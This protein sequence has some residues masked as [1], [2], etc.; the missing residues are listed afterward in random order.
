MNG[1][2]VYG[3]GKIYHSYRQKDED[4]TEYYSETSQGPFAFGNQI[5]SD[6]P[7]SF[8]Q[9]GLSFSKL[10]NVPSYPNYTGWQNKNGTPFHFVS[11]ED[12]DKLGDESTVEYCRGIIE[13]AASD[14][15]N[16]PFFLTAGF[17]KPHRPFHIPEKYWDLYDADNFNMMFYQ[18]DSMIP[19]N[20]AIVNRFGSHSNKAFDIMRAESPADDPDFY[21]RQYIHGYYA[22]ISFIDDQVGGILMA[23]EEWGLS[24][25]T[26]V[27]FTSDHG[28]HLGSKG[29]VEK[30][31][32]W[33]DA[34]SV[35]FTIKIPGES[36][37][38][39][40]E[41]ISLIDLYP[42]LLTYGN[43]PNPDSHV[44][45]GQPIQNIIN[46]GAE[47]SAILAGAALEYLAVGEV[48]NVEHNHHGFVKNGYK[49]ICYSSGEDE[50]YDIYAD[51]RET[52][53]LSKKLDFQ[54]IRNSMHQQLRQHIGFSF[55]PLAGYHCLYYGD[56]EQDL[57]GWS[58]S[59]PDQNFNI[60]KND[61]ILQ[62]SHL[63]F[64][65]STTASIGNNNI[66]FKNNGVHELRFISYAEDQGGELHVLIKTTADVVYLD[67]IFAVET[68]LS[69]Y[70]ALFDVDSVLIE[71]GTLRVF[72]RTYGE[73]D[74]HI[75]NVFITHIEARTLSLQPCKIATSIQ[76][77][78]S[79]DLL[80][81]ENFTAQLDQRPTFCEGISGSAPQLW[82]QFIPS[83]TSGILGINVSDS[84]YVLELFSNC[85]IEKDPLHCEA[86]PQ[87]VSWYRFMTN[88]TAG[89]KYRLRI[90]SKETV[91]ENLVDNEIFSLFINTIPAEIETANNS[92]L[93]QS[94]KIRVEHQPIFDHPMSEIEFSFENT[95]TGITTN[96][97]LD[98]DT[99]LEYSLSQFDNLTP[100]NFYKVSATYSSALTETDIPFGAQKYF[101][102]S[103]LETPSA[104]GIY[105][106]PQ[107]SL[108]SSLNLVFNTL[109][110]GEGSLSL[111]DLLG[112]QVYTQQITV[113]SNSI[114]LT[115]LPKLST[116]TYVVVFQ[117]SKKRTSKQLLQVY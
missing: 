64:T 91:T 86:I 23:L 90:T 1:Y 59:E 9:F 13:M 62:S 38:L 101:Y 103:A 116:G 29:L 110:E 75:D 65:G 36:Y 27:I 44:L 114:H 95:L 53:D 47:G 46:G 106:N 54:F 43:I 19:T 42:T 111:Y 72:M 63:E 79:L 37:Q 92:I 107:N 28:F 70:T 89:S 39:I 102:Y 69:R 17:Y 98:F 15:S 77:Y 68:D 10:E 56:F 76:T 45:D 61:S 97:T 78:S 35:P 105:P 88:L 81:G 104:F 73:M 94:N 30:A 26:I 11:D 52:N 22:G 25:N 55:T 24:D 14:T 32:M 5:H 41:P 100:G 82:K 115:N 31:T 117:S 112:R 74:I 34:T 21:L 33:N 48:S 51:F 57:N 85:N 66:Q 3:G 71:L 96:T 67:T 4:F 6:L 18:P 113:E 84:D 87:N 8:Q 7:E 93:S 40:Q 16:Q 49:Y 50:L 83:A 109:S 108:S 99:T 12:R 80:T 20:T 2:L 60:V 58:P